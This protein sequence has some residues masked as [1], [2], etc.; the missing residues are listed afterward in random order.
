MIISSLHTHSHTHTQTGTRCLLDMTRHQCHNTRFEYTASSAL[1]C[2]APPPSLPG[3]FTIIPFGFIHTTPPPHHQHQHFVSFV[4]RVFKT[5]SIS[6]HFTHIMGQNVCDK[7]AVG[8]AAALC[9][10][11]FNNM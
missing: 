11:V 4:L 5:I 7:R 9:K 6:D 1:Y 8:V 2:H 10:S 3:P